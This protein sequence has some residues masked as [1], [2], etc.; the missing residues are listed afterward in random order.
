MFEALYLPCAKGGAKVYI[1]NRNVNN[2]TQEVAFLE[3]LTISRLL[4]T[5][6]GNRYSPS[7]HWTSILRARAGLT[8]H[9]PGDKATSSFTIPGLKFAFTE[10]LAYHGYI[11]TAPKE[12][13]CIPTYHLEVVT[14][15]GTL[16]NSKFYVRGDQ[17]TKLC[18]R[19]EDVQI[20]RRL[21]SL[22]AQRLHRNAASPDSSEVSILVRISSVL[23]EPKISFFVDPW[24][25]VVDGC[26]AANN[27]AHHHRSFVPGK[28]PRHIDMVKAGFARPP[29]APERRFEK[30]LG[31]VQWHRKTA[32]ASTGPGSLSRSHIPQPTGQHLSVASVEYRYAPLKEFRG[33]SIKGLIRGTVPPPAG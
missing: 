17:I 28:V 18:A 4:E 10:F 27:L 9:E 22:Q 12:P 15:E 19:S 3:E 7:K 5:H 26:L 16:E 6:L 13:G 25:L 20:H 30:T 23:V 32:S 1:F 29:T 2:V 14:T 21:T 33:W 11:D 31:K 24:Q 8:P